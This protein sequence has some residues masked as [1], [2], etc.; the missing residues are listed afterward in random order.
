MRLR[1]WLLVLAALPGL[2]PVFGPATARAQDTD[3]IA[4]ATGGIALF[5]YIP[6]VLAEQIGAFKNENLKVEINDFQGGQRSIE[7]LV[8]GSVDV[9]IATYENVPLLQSKGV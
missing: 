8:G 6:I 1:S 2:V 9:A 4:I 5:N 7:A 3:T